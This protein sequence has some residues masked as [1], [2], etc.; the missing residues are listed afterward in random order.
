MKILSTAAARTLPKAPRRRPRA[1]VL[2]FDFQLEHL[3]LGQ[4]AAASGLD[5]HELALEKGMVR[6]TGNT[7]VIAKMN[8][9]KVE[10]VTLSPAEIAAIKKF[11]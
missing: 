2:S 4:S 7:V 6:R 5:S 8:G 1:A 10:T 11:L 3:R 9:N